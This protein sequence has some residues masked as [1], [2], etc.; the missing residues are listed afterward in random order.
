MD[1]LTRKL[2]ERR[3]AELEGGDDLASL[4]PLVNPWRE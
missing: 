1:P 3:I 4:K 2:L